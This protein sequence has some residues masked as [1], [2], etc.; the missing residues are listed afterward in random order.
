MKELFQQKINPLIS[1][2]NTHQIYAEISD[3]ERL[4]V[5][6]QTHAFAVF[7]FMSLA[8]SLQGIFAPIK[9]TWTPPRNQK[10][11]RFMNEII[12]AEESDELPNGGHMSHFEMYCQAMAEVKANSDLVQAF[13]RFME[14]KDFE[15]S[16]VQLPVPAEAEVFM[17][18]TFK[19]INSGDEIQIAASFC[20]GREKVIPLMFEAFLSKMDI[21]EIQAP[22]FHFYLKR[23]IEVDGDSHGPLAMEMLEVLC[24]NDEDKWELAIKSAESALNSRI[25]LWDQLLDRIRDVK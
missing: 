21:C 13:S 23:H 8:K 11:C 14:D 7:D 4:R 1:E 17:R 5:F 2:L 25:K 10:L 16:V 24:E 3:I 9:P 12:L 18:D 20:F 6:M 22:M 15:Q 19:T